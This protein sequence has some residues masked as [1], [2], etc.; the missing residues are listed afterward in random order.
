M[1]TLKVIGKKV[2]QNV[3]LIFLLPGIVLFKLAEWTSGDKLTWNKHLVA[4]EAIS[5]YMRGD[6]DRHLKGFRKPKRK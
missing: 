3:S 2:R 6:Y 4:R 5:N 1:E